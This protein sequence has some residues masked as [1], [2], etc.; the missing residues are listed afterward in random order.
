MALA[1]ATMTSGVVESMRERAGL[2]VTQA[3]KA[4][5]DHFHSHMKDDRFTEEHARK[6]HYTPRQGEGFDR[7]SKE[8]TPTYVANKLRRKGHTRPLV[9]SGKTL[10][11]TESHRV[12][13]ISGIL[14]GASIGEAQ[15]RYPQARGLNRRNPHS[16]VRMR[17]EFLRVLPEERQTLAGV[18]KKQLA[19]QLKG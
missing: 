4:M 11:S 2:A 14:T 16:S 3:Y 7:A 6:A 13:A 19:N 15:V 5:G 1:K 17:E 8:F 9:F 12:D 18:F 10:R